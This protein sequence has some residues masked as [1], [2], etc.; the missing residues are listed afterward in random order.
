MWH[1]DETSSKI[2]PFRDFHGEEAS[3]A[4]DAQ[5]G[6]R[7]PYAPIVEVIRDC[8]KSD[9]CQRQKRLNHAVEELG[10][11]FSDV[12]SSRSSANP[13]RLDLFPLSLNAAEWQRIASG[14][15]QRALAFNAYAQ[16]L[17]SEQQILRERVIPHDLALRDPAFLRPLSG[18]EVP[19]GEYSQFGAFDLVDAGE[20]DWRVVENH[21][22]APFGLSH[23]LQNRRILSQVFPELYERVGVAPVAG[24]STYLLEMLRAQSSRANPH[25]LLLTSGQPG[26]AY[27][28]EAFIARHMGI[29]IAQ[30]GD[31]LVRESRVF[32]K[33]I[34]GLEPVDVIYRRVESSAL[35]PIAVPNANAFGLPGLIN[36]WRQGNIAIV[37]APGA[38]VSDNRALLRYSD[39]IVGQYRNESPILR[40]VET[41][42]LSDIDQRDY[43]QEHADQLVLKP[44]QDHD[45][46]WQLCGGRPGKSAAS[47]LHIAKQHPEYFVAQAIPEPAK[48]PQYRDGEFTARGGYLRVYYILGKEPIVLPGGMVQQKVIGHRTRRLTIATDGLKDVWVPDSMVQDTAPKRQPAKTGERFSISSRVA[49]SLYWAGRYLERAENTS[50]QFHTLERLRWDQMAH[51]EQRTYWPLLQAVATATGQ[52]EVTKRKRPPRDTLP[53][54]R[55]LLL[56]GNKGASVRA[57]IRSA[58]N[59]LDRVREVIS[60]ECREVLEDISLYL[61]VEGKR[62]LNRARLTELCAHIVSELARFN[63]TAERTMPHDDTWQF[64]RIGIF[65]E[66]AVGVLAVLKVAMPRLVEAYHEVDEESA[67]LTALLRLLGSLDAYRREF[68]SRAYVDRICSLILQSKHVPSSVNFCLRN[69]DYAIST[70][71]YNGERALGSDLSEQIRS[72]LQV[73]AIFPLAQSP[74]DEVDW[75]DAGEIQPKSMH[76]TAE[77][78]GEAFEGL[79][80]QVEALHGRLEDIFFSHQDVFARE[81]TLFAME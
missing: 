51:A 64:F 47:L 68:R 25:I 58:R 4:F 80:K 17:Y 32:L 27:F 14:V 62:K 13:W 65:F 10:L 12:T 37:N 7:Q 3:A 78:V 76:H 1:A 30:P 24:F 60:P 66:R 52:S 46:L 38:G 39:R 34:R 22:G 81:P 63:G 19:Y 26:Q 77:F 50:R 49:E 44:M 54:S 79:A 69:L 75:L 41:F 6:A 73:L 35:D 20:G 9:L 56:D 5:G 23:V 29:S 11:Q 21:M 45:M 2:D 57:C 72:L 67:D 53:F 48:I 28:E 33:T 8:S 16:D 55:S 31:L 70:L 74:M 40:S 15:V 59:S 43:V 18:I 42:H 36:A 71:S 61:N